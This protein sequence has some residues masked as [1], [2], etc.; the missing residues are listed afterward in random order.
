MGGKGD[1]ASAGSAKRAPAAATAAP[2][3]RKLRFGTKLLYGFGSVAY[4]IKDNGFSTLLLLFYNQVVGLPADVVG[5]AVL[6][7]LIIDAFIDPVIGQLSDRLRSRWGRRHP[8]M[9]MAAVPV[10][11]LYLSL[12]FPPF[13]G[14][15]GTKLTWLF[16]MAV[17]VRA[18]ISCYEVPSSALAPELT[19]DYNERTSL[20]AY[21]YLFGWLG[22]MTMFLI[23]FVVF[24]APTDAYPVGQLNPGGYRTYAVVA[25]IG[26]IVAIVMS[27]VGTHPEIKHLP[28]LAPVTASLK[29]TLTGLVQ[30]FKN[31]AFRI[32]LLSGVFAFTAQGLLFSL[33]TYF[34]TYYWQFPATIIGLFTFGVIAGAFLAFAVAT[35]VSRRVGK[36]RAAVVCS[37]LFPVV[38]VAP[39]LARELGVFPANGT[40]GLLV[41]Q[42]VM[43]AL[44]TALGVASTI[45]GASMMS[46]A[47]EDEQER[48]GQRTEGLFFAGSFFMQKCVTGLGIF[49]SGAILA[50]IG[51]PTGA[52]PGAVDGSVLT[53][54]ALIYSGLAL[55]LGWLA[56]FCFSRFPLGGQR[57]HEER[58]ARLGVIVST[59]APLPG[60]EAELTPVPAVPQPRF[61]V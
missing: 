9:Y 17:L 57:D 21:R 19:A 15:T 13:D 51:F 42:P 47:V 45:I 27:S 56:S 32:L 41:A 1:R 34:N 12:W 46:D 14:S 36:V 26:M 2:L 8:F 30:A 4:G 35:A 7:A 50:L 22:G 33:T 16:T 61:G 24:L 28:Q 48:T 59:A 23:T 55:A 10:A 52:T 31:R 25:S 58:L 37:A 43:M 38:S 5:L 18:A 49:L 20:L 29:G 40:T 11:V 44:A 60:S 39:F 6:V 3:A 54:L 53:R